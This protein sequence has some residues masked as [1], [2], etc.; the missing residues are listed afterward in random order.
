[1]QT[2]GGASY[3]HPPEEGAGARP[4]REAQL[5]VGRDGDQLGLWARTNAVAVAVTGSQ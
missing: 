1:M 5:P 2:V 3:L 4:A